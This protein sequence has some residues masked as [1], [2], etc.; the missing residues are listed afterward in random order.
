M[1][2]DDQIAE[3]AHPFGE[4]DASAGDGAHFAADGAADEQA[5]P[6]AAFLAC[7]AEAVADGSFHGQSQAALL[8]REAAGRRGFR[9]QCV[10]DFGT[11]RRLAIRRRA[12]GRARCR[13][14]LRLRLFRN[15]PRQAVDELRQ[16]LLVALQG[17]D[18]LLLGA[19]PR[20]DF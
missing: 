20:G 17:A 9:Q 13:F 10:L 7:G 14:R 11:G 5:F 12:R 6:G 1:I 19:D 18:L 16:P 4:N 3:T 2:D 15:Q 8:A